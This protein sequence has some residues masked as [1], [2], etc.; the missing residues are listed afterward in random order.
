MTAQLKTLQDNVH[1]TQDEVMV[2]LLADPCIAEYSVLAVRE[3]W[4]NPCVLTT[5]NL[6]N[7]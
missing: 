3:T 2:P 7:L 1:T 5:H 6:S 4:R